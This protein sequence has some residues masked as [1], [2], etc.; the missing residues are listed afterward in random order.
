MAATEAALAP[1]AAGL[2]VHPVYQPKP[3]GLADAVRVAGPLIGD[4]R[5]LLLLSDSLVDVGRATRA[6]ETP[7]CAQA[8]ADRIQF[9]ALS[10]IASRPRWGV[11]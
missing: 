6:G 8:G 7:L 2:R 1:V 4:D 9:Q 11:Q 10:T 3:L 5:F